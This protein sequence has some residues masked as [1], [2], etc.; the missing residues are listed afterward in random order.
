LRNFELD[1]LRQRAGRG[2]VLRL[3]VGRAVRLAVLFA[4]CMSAPA[5]AE[6]PLGP[7]AV[8]TCTLEKQRRPG[9]ECLM[10]GAASGDPAKCQKR[11]SPRG[12]QRRCRGNGDSVWMEAWCRPLAGDAAPTPTPRSAPDP[13]GY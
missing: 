1:E 9:E 7:E 13:L 2:R 11:L 10:C 8:E 3:A 4:V 12:Y 5:M 6:E